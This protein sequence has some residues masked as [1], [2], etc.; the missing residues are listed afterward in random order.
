MERVHAVSVVYRNAREQAY[1]TTFDF[2]RTQHPHLPGQVIEFRANSQ[3]LM[4]EIGAGGIDRP[5][6]AGMI[7]ELCKA[8]ELCCKGLVLSP[9][10]SFA[11]QRGHTTVSLVSGSPPTA[12]TIRLFAQGRQ[13]F[14][15]LGDLAAVFQSPDALW[16]DFLC[17]RLPAHRDWITRDL[18]PV[19]HTVKNTFRNPSAHAVS[20]KQS[21]AEQLVAYLDS[22]GFF[23][24]FD[25]IAQDLRQTVG[26]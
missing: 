7:V 3:F 18:P 20:A 6:F 23:D 26:D 11:Q 5:V 1:R 21:D 15:G 9:F 25:Q 16:A 13:P 14:L 2:L 24:R 8:V 10:I 12:R 4:S 17:A 22:T 19:V